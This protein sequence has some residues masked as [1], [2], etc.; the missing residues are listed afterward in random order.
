MVHSWW[1]GRCR[2]RL[3]FLGQQFEGEFMFIPEDMERSIQVLPDNHL[4][5]RGRQRGIGLQELEELCVERNGPIVVD[6]SSVLD[7]EDVG[8]INTRGRAMDVG[9]TL[10]VGK[11]LVVC[12]RVKVF[13]EAIGLFYCRDA[14]FS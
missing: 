6:V 4:R 1:P 5:T 8:K 3:G 7:T 12:M 14:V 11:A 2:D 10:R 13:K 9:Q